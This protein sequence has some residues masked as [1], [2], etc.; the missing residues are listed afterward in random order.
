MHNLIETPL[1]GLFHSNSTE[2]WKTCGKTIYSVAVG[3]GKIKPTVAGKIKP[4]IAGFI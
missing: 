1:D 4:F 2:L 3:D